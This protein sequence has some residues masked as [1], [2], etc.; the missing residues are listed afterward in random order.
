MIAMTDSLEH[1][2]LESGM[3]PR[4]LAMTRAL[5]ARGGRLVLRRGSPE[6]ALPALIREIGAT[7]VFWNRCYQPWHRARDA[8]LKA[9]LCAQGIEVWNFKGDALWEP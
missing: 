6:T 8:R 1:P 7:A 2:E 9:A 4:G 3:R 5:A